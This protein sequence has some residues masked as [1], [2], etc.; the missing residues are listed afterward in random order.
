M[1]ITLHWKAE[2]TQMPWYCELIQNRAVAPEPLMT[3]F[4]IKHSQRSHHKYHEIFLAIT[5]QLQDNKYT[6]P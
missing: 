1:E 5:N 6:N 3:T 4:E 2:S